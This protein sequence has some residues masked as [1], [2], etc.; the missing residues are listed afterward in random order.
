MSVYN[1]SY[2]CE[3]FCLLSYR[4]CAI[5]A[6]NDLVQ[7]LMSGGGQA[8][9]SVVECYF[10]FQMFRSGLIELYMCPCNVS[11]DNNYRRSLHFCG[12]ETPDDTV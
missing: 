12:H 9:V 11:T 2:L 5:R 8:A 10:T 3:H 1:T 4:E 7:F 6:L